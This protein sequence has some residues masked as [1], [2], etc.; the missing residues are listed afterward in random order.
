M[1]DLPCTSST[2]LSGTS[3]PDS[4]QREAARKCSLAVAAFPWND[5]AILTAE[6]LAEAMPSDHFSLKYIEN[7]LAFEKKIYSPDF[8]TSRLRN[9]LHFIPQHTLDMIDGGP[10]KY[11]QVFCLFFHYRLTGYLRNEIAVDISDILEGPPPNLP[12]HCHAEQLYSSCQPFA[13]KFKDW[14]VVLK[15]FRS[16][17]NSLQELTSTNVPSPPGSGTNT[18]IQ[19]LL[20]LARTA[21]QENAAAIFTNFAAAALYLNHL[22][23]EPGS[24]GKKLPDLPDGKLGPELIKKWCQNN[25]T[26]VDGVPQQTEDSDEQDKMQE[27]HT[28]AIVVV[29]HSQ[30]DSSDN[31]G[32]STCE[33]SDQD[34]E[35]VCKAIVYISPILLLAD[36]KIYR[37]SWNQIDILKYVKDLGNDTPEIIC[38]VGGMVFHTLVNLATG[39]KEICS[40]LRELCDVIPWDELELQVEETRSWFSAEHHHAPQDVSLLAVDFAEPLAKGWPLHDHLRQEAGL[41]FKVHGHVP[42]PQNQIPLEPS[43]NDSESTM[44]TAESS[45]EVTNRGPESRGDIV[46][47]VG[48]EL[49]AVGPS[50]DPHD[51]PNDIDGSTESTMT[52]TESS[53]EVTN[54]GLES[55]GDIVDEVGSE[56]AAVGPS[57]DPHNIDGSTTRLNSTR[58][59]AS[60][61]AAEGVS[62]TSESNGNKEGTTQS[63]PG[64]ATELKAAS[65]GASNS[66]STVPPPAGTLDESVAAAVKRNQRGLKMR[67][68]GADLLSTIKIGPP[69]RKRQLKKKPTG[70]KLVAK[71]V[72]AESKSAR[73]DSKAPG[74]TVNTKKLVKQS[75]REH[76]WEPVKV[77]MEYESS[78]SMQKLFEPVAENSKAE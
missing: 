22:L 62:R 42:A 12:I 66:I 2:S 78:V 4:S 36:S 47:E 23:N 7:I 67:I 53:E 16:S 21:R 64:P 29:E 27:D 77:K 76:Y 60:N 19:L 18:R 55:R 68:A 52:M 45:E 20:S 3:L 30:P 74:I 46:G 54:R 58:D 59:A 43:S 1:L 40:A 71:P 69:R 38:R 32:Q 28:A 48:S 49:A 24:E 57:G 31:T 41:S 25:I 6:N 5:R 72:S 14:T 50:G 15:R 35:D 56:L 51:I 70:E 17:L 26:A 63:Q 65:T 44:T 33:L 73:Q 37:W 61:S 75:L 39:Q 34:C 9:V 10:A 11:R 8:E 13:S